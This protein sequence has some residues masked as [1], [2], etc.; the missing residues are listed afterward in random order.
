MVSV[1]RFRQRSGELRDTADQQIT[2]TFSDILAN[3]ARMGREAMTGATR[4]GR[5]MGLGDSSKFRNQNQIQGRLD[6]TQGNAV[7][8]R[9]E[10]R[11]ENTNM[12]NARMDQAQG[13]EDQANTYKQ[14]IEG[15]YGN[16]V[17]NAN[18]NYQNAIA[19]LE[20]LMGRMGNLGGGIS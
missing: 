1:G 10:N 15:T 14:Q 8:Q 20:Q 4:R 2:N 6:Q 18:S 17:G 11:L 13:K 19:S 12:Y 16:L 3:N 5:A 9:G 7:A